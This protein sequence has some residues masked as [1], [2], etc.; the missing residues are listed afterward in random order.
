[1]VPTL[2]DGVV[3]LRAHRPD[4]ARGSFE[5]CQD[6]SSQ[7]WTTVPVPYSMDD[8]RTFVGSICPGGWD[9]GSEWA[10]AV[11]AEGRYAGTVSLRPEGS[12]RAEIAYGSHPWVRGTGHME[13]GLRLLLDWG[14]EER[15]LHTVIWWAHV[16]NWA[17][18][19]LAWWLGFTVEGE[20]RSWQA[21]RGELQDSWVGT[22]LRDDPRKPATPWLDN[23]VVE[24]D[25]VR[26]RPFTEDDVPRVVEGIGD[27]ETQ[28][29]LAFLPRDPG[30]AEGRHYLEQVTQRLATNHTITW[31]WTAAGD[32]LLLGA[33]GLYRIAGEPEVGYWAHPDARGRGLTTAA[34]RLAV[35]Y[36]FEVLHLPRLAAYASAGNTASLRVLERL[37]MQRTGVQRRAARAGD[38]TLVDLVG[39]D[40][41]AEEW[42][43]SSG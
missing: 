41:L 19:K 38:G 1:M 12:D 5:Q 15:G 27:A 17:S 26:L 36:A 11:E 42:V 16:G 32:D 18:R 40:M 34:A 3:T 33:V 37:G 7:R 35:R 13:R 30:A 2:T 9:D 20:V 22:L 6:P 24:G 43:A 39:Y 31:A 8:A 10:F 21:Q 14:F 28:H 4:D 23:P 25:V 29:R